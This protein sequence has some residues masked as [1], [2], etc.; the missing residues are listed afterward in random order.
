MLFVPGKTET[1]WLQ[2][3]S[4]HKN[5]NNNNNSKNKNKFITVYPSNT[6]LHLQYANY[7]KL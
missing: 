1:L 4:L 2:P 6:T 7:K 5:N 3:K